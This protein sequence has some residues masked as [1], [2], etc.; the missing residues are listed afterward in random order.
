MD[1]Q[2]KVDSRAADILLLVYSLSVQSNVEVMGTNGQWLMLP[3]LNR[4]EMIL[5]F[6]A[7]VPGVSFRYTNCNMDECTMAFSRT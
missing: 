5:S 2:V 6:I 3:D 7:K 1:E 4:A